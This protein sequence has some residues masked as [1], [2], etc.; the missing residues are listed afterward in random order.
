M[1]EYVLGE[2]PYE[3]KRVA[4]RR[5]EV[6]VPPFVSEPLAKAKDTYKLEDA[7]RHA[8]MIRAAWKRAGWEV[9]VYVEARSTGNGMSYRVV[10]P[11]MVNGLPV[12]AYNQ[13]QRKD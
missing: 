12:A 7:E 2:V 9:D 8:S 1:H 6:R 4:K 11:D 3:S 13:M 10:A 5:R